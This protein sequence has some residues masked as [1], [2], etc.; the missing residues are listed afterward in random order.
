[1]KKVLIIN[2]KDSSRKIV[3][4]VSI[5]SN[6]ILLLL[7]AGFIKFR[8]KGLIIVLNNFNEKLTISY[9]IKFLSH[10]LTIFLIGILSLLGIIFW[11]N[12]KW[13]FFLTLFFVST[14]ITMVILAPSKS[15]FYTLKLLFTL[16]LI[17][18]IIFRNIYN[19]YINKSSLKILFLLSGVFFYSALL[20]F[21]GILK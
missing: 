15:L 5:L 13:F 3:V 2:Q 6:F 11:R 20:F 4:F 18:I 1:M 9:I 12:N 7:F 10:E 16:T 17:Y 14:E 19:V 21:I 8:I